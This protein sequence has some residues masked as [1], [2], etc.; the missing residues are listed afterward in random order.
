[1]EYINISKYLNA[2]KIEEVVAGGESGINARICDFSW[3]LGIRSQ[4]IN[5]NIKF[6]FKQTGAYFFK[7]GKEYRIKRKYQHSQAKKADIDYLPGQRR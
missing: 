1:M 4:C 6:T 7:D 5:N 3:I 2:D